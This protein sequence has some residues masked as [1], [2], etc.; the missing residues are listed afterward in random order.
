[1]QTQTTKRDIAS[2]PWGRPWWKRQ[3]KNRC[4][5]WWRNWNPHTLLEG[6]NMTQPL[7]RMVWSFLKRLPCDPRIPPLGLCPREVKTVSTHRDLP[8]NV[9]STTIHNDK[10]VENLN[11]HQWND[12]I[13]CILTIKYCSKIKW[14]TDTCCDVDKSESLEAKWY[15][16]PSWRPHIVW[17]HVHE[18]SR[19]DKS[20][21]IEQTRGCQ[22][23]EGKRD[24]QWV[25]V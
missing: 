16:S 11:V 7:W 24:H 17:F 23:A 13:W 6:C 18:M 21:G 22:G 3:I 4:W 25:G 20:T 1:M 15:R 14:S 2:C 10:K 19:M 8:M 9:H 5:W 12:K